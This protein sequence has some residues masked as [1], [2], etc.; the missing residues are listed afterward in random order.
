M[1][2]GCVSGDSGP[3]LPSSHRGLSVHGVC[4]LDLGTLGLSLNYSWSEPQGEGYS[5]IETATVPPTLVELAQ[6]LG[7]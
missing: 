3:H 2:G 1:G 4:L 5:R 7:A 6:A